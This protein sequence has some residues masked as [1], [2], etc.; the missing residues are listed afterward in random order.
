M[1]EIRLTFVWYHNQHIIQKN[2]TTLLHN[3]NVWTNKCEQWEGV[4]FLFTFSSHL[5]NF[6]KLFDSRLRLCWGPDNQVLRSSRKTRRSRRSHSVPPK[7]AREALVIITIS[8]TV[9][10]G[11]NQ[12]WCIILILLL[13][14]W[15]GIITA[16]P[17][18]AVCLWDPPKYASPRWR[19]LKSCPWRCSHRSLLRWALYIC[20]NYWKCE[21]AGD[22]PVMIHFRN[23][24]PSGNHQKYLLHSDVAVGQTEVA[25]FTR[26]PTV[27]LYRTTRR[28]A[29]WFWHLKSS[30][31]LNTSTGKAS[32]K[33][34]SKKIKLMIHNSCCCV[35]LKV[36]HSLLRRLCLLLTVNQQWLS[37]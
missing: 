30:R 23:F 21:V 26:C 20:L 18:P 22:I 7:L 8:S 33:G 25:Q 4:H 37:G 3:Y 19:H 36:T 6:G 31:G 14:S 10:H 24:S 32:L 12:C 15:P 11:M 16:F 34:L 1:E 5:K 35:K 13:H 27:S 9:V 28:T 29:G 17:S 2:P